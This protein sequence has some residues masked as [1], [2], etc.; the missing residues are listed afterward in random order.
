MTQ[1][2]RQQTEKKPSHEPGALQEREPGNTPEGEPGNVWVTPDAERPPKRE[3]GAFADPDH[4]P[5]E[6]HT[7]EVGPPTDLG[8][9]FQ[10]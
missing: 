10:P 2:N 7:P 1:E 6:T 8:G 9:G 5:A 4:S 3:E